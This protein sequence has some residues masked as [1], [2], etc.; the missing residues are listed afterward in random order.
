[1][2]ITAKR[3]TLTLHRRSLA[4]NNWGATT[5]HARGTLEDDPRFRQGEAVTTS[6]VQRIRMDGSGMSLQTLNTLYNISD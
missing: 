3:P 6:P 4:V 1:M 5:L 2:P